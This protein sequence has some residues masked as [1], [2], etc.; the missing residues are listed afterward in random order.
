MVHIQKALNQ[1]KFGFLNFAVEIFW[2]NWA[3][4][5]P[6]TADSACDFHGRSYSTCKCVVDHI[7][8]MMVVHGS[9]MYYIVVHGRSNT[10][11]DPRFFIKFSL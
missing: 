8:S 3:G 6:A 9:S 10:Q 5:A 11:V 4:P 7:L 2:E 1:Q